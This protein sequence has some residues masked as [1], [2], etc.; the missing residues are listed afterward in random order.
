VVGD[1]FLPAC[2]DLTSLQLPSGLTAVGRNFLVGCT[3]LTILQLPSGLTTVDDRFLF[4]C[5]D[6]TAIAIGRNFPQQVAD[7]LR[8][9]LPRVQIAREDR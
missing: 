9:R 7:D 3:G 1:Y 8:V 6:L 5:T 4:G 2:S